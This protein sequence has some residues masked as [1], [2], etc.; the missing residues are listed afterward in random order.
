MAGM[1]EPDSE[2]DLPHLARRRM[3]SARDNVQEER[4]IASRRRPIG[5]R[6]GVTAFD[7]ATAEE[8]AAPIFGAMTTKQRQEEVAAKKELEGR[9]MVKSNEQ[10]TL[11]VVLH[12]GSRQQ[13]FLTTVT[14]SIRLAELHGVLKARCGRALP[15]KYR[16][17]WQ[18]GV[19]DCCELASQAV[20]NEF[21]FA[22]WCALPW[23][24]HVDVREADSTESL[25]TS[26]LVRAADRLF[27]R[28]DVE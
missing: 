26:S 15:T 14:N 22:S 12:D 4:D 18:K 21:I 28:Y 16:L 9:R 5:R 6:E 13:V 8:I 11:K 2:D 10:L 24:V 7:G 27:E 23:T 17:L 20:F 25:E 1:D 3:M 19:G